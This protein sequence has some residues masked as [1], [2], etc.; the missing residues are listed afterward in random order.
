MLKKFNCI[1]KV[2]FLLLRNL[3]INLN[4]NYEIVNFS[5]PERKTE[6]R[7]GK[8]KRIPCISTNLSN[9]ASASGLLRCTEKKAPFKMSLQP[10]YIEE[11]KLDFLEVKLNTY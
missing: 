11:K 4:Q 6:K 2:N 9:R 5:K 7:Y 8:K 1:S 3:N 10:H